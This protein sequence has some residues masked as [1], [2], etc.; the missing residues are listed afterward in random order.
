MMARQQERRCWFI[1]SLLFGLMEFSACDLPVMQHKRT[2]LRSQTSLKSSTIHT[3]SSVASLWHFEVFFCSFPSRPRQFLF[4]RTFGVKL[5]ISTQPILGTFNTSSV[6][7][8]NL[9]ES[10]QAQLG[11]FDGKFILFFYYIRRLVFPS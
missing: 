7:K 6:M 4:S 8:D 2:F 9:F 3:N 10:M 5:Q 11:V 1:S